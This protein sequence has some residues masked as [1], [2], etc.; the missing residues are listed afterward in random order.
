MLQRELEKSYCGL[1]FTWQLLSI[2]YKKD[3]IY[4]WRKVMSKKLFGIVVVLGIIDLFIPDVF[5]SME[6]IAMAM[7]AYMVL[8]KAFIKKDQ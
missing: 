1:I 3:D 5:I 8:K 6:E 4:K 2:M 7:T